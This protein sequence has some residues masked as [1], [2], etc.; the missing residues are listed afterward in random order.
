MVGTLSILNASM[1]TSLAAKRHMANRPR[2]ASGRL[3]AV[4][5]SCRFGADVPFANVAETA[6]RLVQSH[7]D[8]WALEIVCVLRG[9]SQQ[10]R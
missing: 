4:A 5:N 1:S 3:L 10:L 2:E 9:W 7:E 8:R 6:C